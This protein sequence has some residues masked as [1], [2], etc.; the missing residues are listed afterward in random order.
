MGAGADVI[1]GLAEL[2]PPALGTAP[3]QL[4][5]EPDVVGQPELAHPCQ[6]RYGVVHARYPGR[7]IE[8]GRLNVGT[9]RH[10]VGAR[11]TGEAAGAKYP[12]AA[13]H[14][15]GPPGRNGDVDDAVRSAEPA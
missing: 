14:G 13:R 9:G 15:D 10:A 6:E 8:D 12:D 3:A 1:D 11:R 2:T 4:G 7:E 5:R